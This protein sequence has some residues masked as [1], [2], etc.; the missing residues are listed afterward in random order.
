MSCDGA[1]S[2]IAESIQ[3]GIEGLHFYQ[4]GLNDKQRL[5]KHYEQRGGSKDEVIFDADPIMW[6]YRLCRCR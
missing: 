2:Y 3:I 4:I 6:Q 5:R 1:F